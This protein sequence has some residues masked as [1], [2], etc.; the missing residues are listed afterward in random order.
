M[1][2]CARVCACVHVPVRVCV[3]ERESLLGALSSQ[4]LL[5]VYTVLNSRIV[6]IALCMYLLYMIWKG[7]FG[8]SLPGRGV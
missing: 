4:S 5:S 2:V 8:L 1:C 3:R 7:L 6:I